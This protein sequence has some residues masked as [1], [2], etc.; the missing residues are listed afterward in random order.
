MKS[1][2][3]CITTKS[4]IAS[5]LFKGLATK[6]TTVNGLACFVHY[7]LTQIITVS[8]GGMSIKCDGADRRKF[9]K[10]LV[11]VPRERV[12]FCGSVSENYFHLQVARY[13]FLA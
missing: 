13:F 8:E 10:K 4:T 1:S 2:K 12:S 5:L 3:V 6:H 11:K 9:Q 7:C